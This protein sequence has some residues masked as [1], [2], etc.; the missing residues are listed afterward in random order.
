MRS[1]AFLTKMT[2]SFQPVP[3]IVPTFILIILIKYFNHYRHVGSHLPVLL[4]SC[5]RLLFFKTTMIQ[6]EPGGVLR[7][8]CRRWLFLSIWLPETLL[9]LSV[10]K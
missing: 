8:S 5:F 3:K 4:P 1:G 2:L 7:R 9:R 6:N 10:N